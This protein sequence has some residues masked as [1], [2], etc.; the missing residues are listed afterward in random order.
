M[1]CVCE[2]E[3]ERERACVCVFMCVRDREKDRGPLVYVKDWRLSDAH[4]NRF[5]PRWEM[6]LI[7]SIN[8]LMGPSTNL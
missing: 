2:R 7:R 5:E 6:D 8:I 4:F 1:C 3:R